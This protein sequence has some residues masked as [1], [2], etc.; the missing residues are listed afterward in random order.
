MF[1]KTLIGLA[2]AAAFAPGMA[3]AQNA[4]ATEGPWLV[5]VRATD[6]LNDNSNDPTL[7]LGQVEVKDR[8]I[9]EFDISYFFND[10]IA[11]E[12]VLTWPQKMDVSLGGTDIGSVKALPPTLLIQYHFMP[13]E[14]F[15]PYVGVGI[16][17]TYFSSQSFSIAGLSTSNSSWGAALQAGLDY[18]IAP[19]WYLN[20]DVKYVWMDTDVSLNGRT[21]TTVD[22]N[23]WLLSVGIGYRF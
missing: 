5:R 6:M 12:L 11:A 23:P 10:N 20:A 3:I 9:P 19:R 22:I 4:L 7:A 1:R 18:K 13:N 16:N 15:R 8:W 17:Y 14:A 21:L 2:L